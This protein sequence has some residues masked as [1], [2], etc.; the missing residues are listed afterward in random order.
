MAKLYDVETKVLNQAVKRNSERFPKEFSF[1]LTIEE[2]DFLRSQVVTLKIKK[3]LG[4]NSE[5]NRNA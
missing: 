5:K 4:L 2:Y 3:E 1:Q